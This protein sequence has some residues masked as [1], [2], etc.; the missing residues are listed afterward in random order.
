LKQLNN[1]SFAQ[2]APKTPGACPAKPYSGQDSLWVH[3]YFLAELS[4][5][6]RLAATRFSYN[7]QAGALACLSC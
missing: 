7:E 5:Q 2:V 4:D 6:V 3:G 1:K